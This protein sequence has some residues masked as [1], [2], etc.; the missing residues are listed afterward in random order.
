[1]TGS[2]ITIEKLLI[3]GGGFPAFWYSFGYGKQMLRQITPK[4]IA[5]YSAG[6]L[7]AVLLLLPDTNTHGIMELFYSTSRCCNI[8]A[9]ES[10]I[11]TTMSACLPNNIHDIANGKLGVILCATN[12]NHKC[13]MV[14]HWE[15][16]EELIDCLVACSYL[17]SATATSIDKSVK[18]TL[19]S[20]AAAQIANRLY[21]LAAEGRI[22]GEACVDAMAAL[23]RAQVRRESLCRDLCVSFMK[24]E[25]PIAHIRLVVQSLTKLVCF[26]QDFVL[27]IEHRIIQ[28]R[29]KLS[30]AENVGDSDLLDA[31]AKLEE[32]VKCY[33]SIGE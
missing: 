25:P 1:M 18:S 31:I 8:C 11:R 20:A 21:P 9:L 22:T 6:S 7:V 32:D 16:K 4:F 23:A 17:S 29:A 28:E 15:S 30:C 13:K 14:I 33:E 19:H 2:K 24:G 27:S 26:Q 3:E 5:G 10:L 12:N